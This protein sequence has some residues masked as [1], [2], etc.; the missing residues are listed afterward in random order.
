[1][2]QERV[3]DGENT[4]FEEKGVPEKAPVRRHLSKKKPDGAQRL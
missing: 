3:N 1:M 4:L 2:R